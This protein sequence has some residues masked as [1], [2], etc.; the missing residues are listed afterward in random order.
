M[1]TRAERRIVCD[2]EGY[3]PEIVL[4]EHGPYEVRVPVTKDGQ[5]KATY[6]RIVNVNEDD[7]HEVF[8]SLE[9][10]AVDVRESSRDPTTALHTIFS[11]I[12]LVRT[13][14]YPPKPPAKEVVN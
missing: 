4:A 13:G 1:V 9:E 10:I 11:A 6:V 14:N 5:V 7:E 8:W 3:G 12:D 2:S